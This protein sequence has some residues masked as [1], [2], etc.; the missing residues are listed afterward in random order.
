MTTF[1]K[2]NNESSVAGSNPQGTDSEMLEVS[3]GDIRLFSE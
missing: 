3:G 2:T 1:M